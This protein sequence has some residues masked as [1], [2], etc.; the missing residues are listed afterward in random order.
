MSNCY[1]GTL[2]YKGIR[3]IRRNGIIFEASET[4]LL[5]TQTCV[6]KRILS[7]RFANM[8]QSKGF[9]LSKRTKSSITLI[10]IVPYNCLSWW[11]LYGSLS[12][13]FQRKK[14]QRKWMHLSRNLIIN[15]VETSV[16][17]TQADTI[18]V[19][20]R[21]NNITSLQHAIHNVSSSD[22]VPT[23]IINVR[24][25]NLFFKFPK[26]FEKL[27]LDYF[28]NRMSHLAYKVCHLWP[29]G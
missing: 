23:R 3:H 4:V 7:F 15:R 29:A 6:D 28:K 8:V 14:A 18:H 10:A 25:F 26:Q 9:S 17:S 24:L 16:C 11:T 12:N 5:K 20:Q 21:K 2:I 22:N 1:F 19:L 27:N 13:N